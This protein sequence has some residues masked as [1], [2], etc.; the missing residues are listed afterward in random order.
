MPGSIDADCGIQ[1]FGVGKDARIAAMRTA[2]E[3]RRRGIA[4]A[5]L[6]KPSLGGWI[7]QVHPGGIRRRA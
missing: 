3:M 2:D 1:F 7:V 6:F 4:A 5:A